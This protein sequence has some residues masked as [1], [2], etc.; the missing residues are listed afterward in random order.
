MINSYY[1]THNFQGSAIATMNP[2]LAAMSKL[3]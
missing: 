3:I 2:W 1:V